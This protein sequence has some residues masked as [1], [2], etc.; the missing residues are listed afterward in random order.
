MDIQK[1]DDIYTHI[2]L[3]KAYYY[4]KTSLKQELDRLNFQKSRSLNFLDTIEL[5]FQKKNLPKLLMTCASN[6]SMLKMEKT[7]ELMKIKKNLALKAE[8]KSE[9]A[10]KALQKILTGS[11]KMNNNISIDHLLLFNKS[12]EKRL[13]ITRQKY[14]ETIARLDAIS[15]KYENM[16]AKLSKFKEKTRLIVTIKNE[17]NSLK[18]ALNKANA[19][20]KT[21]FQNIEVTKNCQAINF[22]K[23]KLFQQILCQKK[24][25]LHSRLA[26]KKELLKILGKA[27]K[28]SELKDNLRKASTNGRLFLHAKSSQS[29]DAKLPE[30]DLL[31]SI[32]IKAKSQQKRI[33]SMSQIIDFN[34]TTP[35]SLQLS[36]NHT[37]FSDLS[38]ESF[39]LDEL[40]DSKDSIIIESNKLKEDIKNI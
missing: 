20:N 19:K 4:R 7:V 38:K 1:N 29:I 17:V 31:E 24:L 34:L 33:L 15:I 14:K 12:G 10:S 8:E 23:A 21:L 40:S 18:I 25:C 30:I 13:A 9:Y 35:K 2:L 6:L 26:L 3:L 37:I 11:P 36:S 32:S 16:K 28:L 5:N 22:E 27:K 39:R